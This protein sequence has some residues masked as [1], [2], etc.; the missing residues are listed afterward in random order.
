MLQLIKVLDI[1]DHDL[2]KL[3][4][5]SKLEGYGF[6]E[7]LVDEYT[8][9]NNVFKLDNELLLVGVDEYGVI[10]AVGAIQKD[11]Y[12]DD[13]RIGRIRHVFVHS[14]YRHM[15]IATTV[16]NALVEFGR[17]HFDIIRLRVSEEEVSPFYEGLGFV[18]VE[19]ESA[20]HQFA[21]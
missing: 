10:L 16:V 19:S 18:S 4:F 21:C 12:L 17:E 20:S 7:R 2:K 9:G 3:V 11:P 8:Q 1:E 14:S 13:S 6:V 5:D 15:G